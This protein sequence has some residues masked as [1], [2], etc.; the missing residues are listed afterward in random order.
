MKKLSKKLNNINKTK[1]ML[2]TI[3]SII[4]LIIIIIII[5]SAHNK[6]ITTQYNYLENEF[7]KLGAK[8]AKDNNIYASKNNP[9]KIDVELFKD[10]SKIKKT[11]LYNSQCSGY[12]K[13]YYNDKKNKNIAKTYLN[14]KKYITPN[15]FKK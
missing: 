11:K 4:F 15:Y 3:W 9:L 12:I 8:Y 14:C 13:I 2:I 10:N 5:F 6:R 7:N 1:T